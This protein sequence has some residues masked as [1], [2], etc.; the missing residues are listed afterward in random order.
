[1]SLSDKLL[2]SHMQQK[3]LIAAKAMAEIVVREAEEGKEPKGEL[4][5]MAKE[6]LASLPPL[7]SKSSKHA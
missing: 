3:H 1:M 7:P 2:E 6:Y 4:Y 5:L